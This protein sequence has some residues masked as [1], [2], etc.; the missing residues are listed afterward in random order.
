MAIGIRISLKGLQQTVAKLT[1]LTVAGQDAGGS[2]TELHRRYGIQAMKWIHE[3]F[4]REGGLL[5]DDPWQELSPNTIAARRKGSS[6]I[7]QNTREKLLPSFNF[8]HTSTE[9]RVGSPEKLA[10]WH[11]EG[12]GIEGPRHHSYFIYPRF[13]KA[14]AFVVAQGGTKITRKVAKRS[15]SF[16]SGH[17]KVN[18][19]G[20]VVAAVTHPGVAKRRMLPN[21]NELLPRLIKTT[22]NWLAQTGQAGTISIDSEQ[23]G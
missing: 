23:D 12:T 7:L 11:N 4:K 5:E 2:K 16:G 21:E 13:K 8:D 10:L 14:L 1:A 6:Q 18:K 20:I 17:L 19:N 22:E 15:A 9:V 3:N